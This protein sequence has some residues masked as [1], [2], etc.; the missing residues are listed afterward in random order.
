MMFGSDRELITWIVPYLP[1]GAELE[2]R[3][4]QAVLQYME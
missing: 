1:A 4:S 2:Y 3:D